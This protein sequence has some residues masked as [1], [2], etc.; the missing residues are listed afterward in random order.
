MKERS[1][2]PITKVTLTHLTLELETKPTA[3]TLD[4]SAALDYYGSDKARMDFYNNREQPTELL[5]AKHAYSGTQR[6]TSVVDHL[7]D[8]N[9][10]APSASNQVKFG[11]LSSVMRDTP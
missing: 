7:F 1:H 2:K 5:Q 4:L 11:K 10:A 3:A 8:G 6:A 9:P